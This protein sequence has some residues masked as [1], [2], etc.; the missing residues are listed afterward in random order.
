M[1][2]LAGKAASLVV[3]AGKLNPPFAGNTMNL[4]KSLAKDLADFETKLDLV[5]KAEDAAK[6]DGGDAQ[7][8]VNQI[9]DAMKTFAANTPHGAILKDIKGIADGLSKKL[10]ALK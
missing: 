4:I 7:K 9:I 2:V 8:T 5:K 3:T 6:K 1:G 10:Q